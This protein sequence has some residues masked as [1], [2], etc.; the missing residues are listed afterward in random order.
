MGADMSPR[1]IDAVPS[2]ASEF[3]A[4]VES[5]REHLLPHP[6]E[7]SRTNISPD[8]MLRAGWRSDLIN[9]LS[10]AWAERSDNGAIIVPPYGVRILRR[11]AGEK[12]EAAPHE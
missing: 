4:Y 9:V 3:S 1:L 6:E 11:V 5:R 12:A 7:W 10:G 8:D 2:N